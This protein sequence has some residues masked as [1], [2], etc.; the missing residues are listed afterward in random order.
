MARNLATALH[1]FNFRR[2][3]ESRLMTVE[4]FASPFMNW[5]GVKDTAFKSC[6]PQVPRVGLGQD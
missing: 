4:I 6:K 2:W 1:Q 5:L 3:S